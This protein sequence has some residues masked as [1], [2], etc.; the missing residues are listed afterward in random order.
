MTKW[1][2]KPKITKK[3]FDEAKLY[4]ECL[5]KDYKTY[6]QNSSG[7]MGKSKYESANQAKE[8]A[9]QGNELRE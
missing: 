4:F 8:A 3:Y 9:Q 5:V 7:M 6:K 2:N 1:E